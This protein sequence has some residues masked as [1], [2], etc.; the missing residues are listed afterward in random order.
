MD[1]LLLL[2]A[3]LRFFSHETHSLE[4]SRQLNLTLSIDVGLHSRAYMHILYRSDCSSKLSKLL[5]QRRTP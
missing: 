3:L 5:N 1:G 4:N 2:F